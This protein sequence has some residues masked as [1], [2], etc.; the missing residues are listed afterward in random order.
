MKKIVCVLIVLTAFL[1]QAGLAQEPLQTRCK[2][3]PEHRQFDFWVGEWEVKDNEGEI[4]GNSRIELTVGDCA[5][6]E[7][8]N[9]TGSYS[10]KSLNYYNY[11]DQ[12]WHQKWMGSG[13]NAIEFSGAYD[14]EAEAMKFT[15]GGVTPDGREINYKLT[16]YKL[17]PHH[18][19]QHWERSLDGGS[20]WTTIFDGH[21]YRK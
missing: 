11:Q 13:G 7:H 5:I 15:G 8:W 3:E 19:R 14:A 17:T 2:V 12:K 20:T 9:S 16:F 4:I 6:L 18:I 10:G 21:Y 1:S